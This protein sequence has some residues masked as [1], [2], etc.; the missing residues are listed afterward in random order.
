MEENEIKASL[1]AFEKD[2][3]VTA[4]EKLVNQIKTAKNNFLKD[5]LELKNDIESKTPK[6]K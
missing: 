6:K 4:K 5:K 2:D 3:F 1:D